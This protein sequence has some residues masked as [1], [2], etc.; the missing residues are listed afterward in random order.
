MG[1]ITIR[2]VVEEDL[3]AIYEVERVSFK[4]FYP[5]GFIKE[6][7]KSNS[8]TFLVAEIE[9]T[10]VGYVIAAQDWGSGHILSIAVHPS[11]RRKNIGRRL[12]IEV[13]KV[14][15]RLGV[16][17]VRLEVRRSNTGA[18]RFY[19]ELGFEYSHTVDRYYLDED[20]LVYYKSL[21]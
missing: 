9:G 12:V 14:L 2:R 7:H 15:Q 8:Q 6:L 18:Q 17:N 16:T 1:E 21:R 13:L 4:D 11:A 3:E 19:E 20:A 10:P 5:P